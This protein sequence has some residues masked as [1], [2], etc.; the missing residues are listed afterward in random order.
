[1][2]ESFILYD[3]GSGGAYLGDPADGAVL[4][5]GGSSAVSVLTGYTEGVVPFFVAD[6]A[7][8]RPAGIALD[9]AKGWAVGAWGAL[10]LVGATAIEDDDTVTVS[11][12]GYRTESPVVP[13]PG[14]ISEAFQIDAKVPLDPTQ[15][16]A[17]WQWGTLRVSNADGRFDGILLAW[18]SAGRET[19]IRWGQ[20]TW[21]DSRGIWEDP[22]SASLQVVF[23][24]VAGPWTMSET[25][26]RIP[27]RD[28]TYLAERPVQATTYGGGGL[29][30]GDA[31]LAGTKKPMGRGVL[32]NVPAKLID[33][34]NLIYQFTD[35]AF[36]LATLYESGGATITFQATTTDLY[37]GTTN[38]GQY[39]VDLTRGLIQVGSTPV[40]P[41]T[42]DITAAFPTAGS[43]TNVV[44]IAYYIL[45]EQ[46]AVPTSAI[47]LAS[48]TDAA[49]AC[50]YA[51][52]IWVPPDSNMDG[53]EAAMYLL[54]SIHAKLAPGLDGKLRVVLLRAIALTDVATATFDTTNILIE[55]D[56]SGGMVP[57]DMPAALDPPPYRVRVQYQRNYQVLTDQLSGSITAAQRQFVAAE[58]RYAA[59]ASI[60]I[61]NS[62]TNPNDLAP[63]GGALDNEADALDVAE[64]VGTLLADRPFQ[65]EM[66]VTIA[67][68]L[69]VKIGDVVYVQYPNHALSEGK[70]CRVVGRSFAS[71][72]QAIKLLILT[73]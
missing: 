26:L 63:F 20:K 36:T 19:T 30:D 22:L 68:G 28:Y 57:V 37:T 48:F 60:V 58:F 54:G 6:V 10:S 49:T 66:K 9:F 43:L 69:G 71:A 52:G 17:T 1:M 62:W 42:A 18:N 46:M 44:W 7:I 16:G 55:S 56:G 11:D 23:R 53:I 31:E 5:F 33:R 35:G 38:P 34:T 45:T 40:G 67:D 27:L 29:Y 8:Y 2:S 72:D 32:R 21:D 70:L 14:L 47:D 51:G 12:I 41:L 13:Y 73:A 39:R 61:S 24:G 4:G 59:W 50:P 64:A 65:F 25:E 3:P 15:I